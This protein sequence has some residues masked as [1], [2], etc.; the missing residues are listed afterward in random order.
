MAKVFVTLNIDELKG[1]LRYGHKEGT[2]EIPDE[3]MNSFKE[4]PL[5]YIL[6]N[7]LQYDL[8]LVVDDFDVEWVSDY[9]DPKYKV[10][11]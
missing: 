8:E 5:K 10:V 2:I 1:Y 11:E 6:E 7:D 4:N 9:S 3:E